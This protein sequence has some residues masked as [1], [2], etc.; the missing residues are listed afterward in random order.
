MGPIPR[1]RANFEKLIRTVRS[2]S[3]NRPIHC[4]HERAKTPSGV[5][6]PKMK[7]FLRA[8]LKIVRLPARLRTPG[9]WIECPKCGVEHHL[10]LAFELRPLGEDDAN[11]GKATRDGTSLKYAV[12]VSL[13]SPASP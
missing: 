3:T 13:Q 8:F 9:R 4:H 5:E 6:C 7:D 11:A 2:R 1:E 10:E 12:G